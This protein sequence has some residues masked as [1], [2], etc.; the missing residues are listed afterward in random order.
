M[1]LHQF[2]YRSDCLAYDPKSNEWSTH[3]SMLSAREEAASATV[4]P[5]A[6]ADGDMFVMGGIVAGERSATV[7]RLPKDRD[8]GCGG[9]LF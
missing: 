5:E 4:R 6:G 1:K 9:K 8:A 7:E 2:I 3:N